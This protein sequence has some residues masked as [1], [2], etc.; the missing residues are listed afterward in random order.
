MAEPDAKRVFVIHG[1]NDA[2]RREMFTFLRAI[3]LHPIE[4][5]EA[6]HATGTASPYIGQVLDTAFGMAQAIVVLMT[7]DEIAYLIPAYSHG[8][9]DPETQ[10]AA[11]AR[12]NVL[13][14]AGMAM[15]RDPKRTVLV[16]LG[17]V[18]PFSDVS[19]LHAVRLAPTP[20]KRKDLAQRLKT[21][22]C[23]VNLNGDD[24]MQTGDFTAPEVPGAGRPL[25]RRVPSQS[26]QGAARV[27]GRYF[28]RSAGSDQLQIINRSGE[29]LLNLR[30]ENLGDYPGRIMGFPI[31]RLPA[32][33]DVKLMTFTHGERDRF[34][35]VI[36]GQT[37]GGEDFRDSVFL[38]FNG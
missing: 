10:P 9:H 37:E 20:E 7:P 30:P 11:Q 3:G 5:S 12:P 22:G 17:S 23:E 8:E 34:D 2:A 21:A 27:D 18:R 26:G 31:E 32:F 38:D 28:K 14:E 16:E 25:G 24:W 1:R 19:G 15:G 6:L 35:L 33:K 29:N 4:W 36:V 13:F